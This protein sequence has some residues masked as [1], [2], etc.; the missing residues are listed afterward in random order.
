MNG[1]NLLCY[2]LSKIP[3]IAIILQVLSR[4]KNYYVL[5]LTTFRIKKKG[6]ITS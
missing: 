3:K 4:I 6:F 5:E 2:E 1:I